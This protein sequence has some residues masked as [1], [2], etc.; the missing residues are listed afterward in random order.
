MTVIHD[1]DVPISHT[2]KRI[3]YFQSE[4]RH[5]IEQAVNQSAVLWELF[6]RRQR[7]GKW[8][9][10]S[11]KEKGCRYAY[12]KEQKR[13]FDFSE[14]YFRYCCPES[15]REPEEIPGN[16]RYACFF[17]LRD[18][19]IWEKK[20]QERMIKAFLDAEWAENAFLLISTPHIL[21]P[22][23]FGDE[24]ELIRMRP[25]DLEDIQKIVR[26]RLEKEPSNQDLQKVA[27]RLKG[28]SE[29]QI[30]TIL[31]SI[32]R[33][34]G[35]SCELDASLPETRRICEERMKE[36][37][38]V[39]KETAAQKD[40]TIVMMDYEKSGREHR[41]ERAVGLDGIQSWLEDQRDIFLKPEQG[42][43]LDGVEAPKG[44]LLTGIP[45][46]GKSLMAEEAARTLDGATLIK[47]Q[48]DR[49]QSNSFGES[50]SNMR[51]CLER[52]E[53]MAPCVLLIDEVE[54][55]FRVD[56]H[57]HEVKLN[58]LG[59]LLD[60]MQKRTASVFT[61]ITAN[62]IRKIPPELLRDGRLSERF[63]VFMPTG[64]E[65]S[66]ILCEK[67]WCINEE[68]GGR[69]F[70]EEL[71]EQIRSRELGRKVVR[72]IGELGEKTGKW[73]FF[74]G[75]NVTKLVAT[76]NNELRLD[77]G[78]SRP[79]SCEVYEERLIRCAMNMRPHGQTNM[80]DIVEMWFEAR[81][82][83]YL[84][85]SEED[86]LAF[87]GFDEERAAFAPECREACEDSPYDRYLFDVISARIIEKQKKM[88]EKR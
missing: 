71:Q 33:E 56:D 73:P 83:R 29:Y 61:F 19:H 27:K 16:Y 18:F 51:R 87:S 79:Y 53:A 35:V 24:I 17:T 44:V 28:L 40:P 11:Q 64:A 25:I 55:I 38:R 52:I 81:E 62:S 22:D 3:L 65:L 5:I 54:K 30:D 31:E 9:L 50:E 68:T 14:I 6:V 76:V 13:F 75:A 66:R 59:Q 7:E 82:N 34:Y 23:G 69:L 84:S 15:R 12:L 8:P 48:I 78:V 47:F 88:N 4:D 45:G 74:T 58:L 37:I 2:R 46:T 42:R 67:L 77:S 80:R 85:A 49:I 41:A 60:W 20:Q 72:Q 63:F 43:Y 32:R 86:F 1:I 21:I 70:E 36:L 57:T 26:E 10:Q 39:E